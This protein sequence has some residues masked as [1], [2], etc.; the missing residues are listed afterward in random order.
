MDDLSHISS[1]KII[2]QLWSHLAT[3]RK[4]QI[5][6]LFF[7]I[8]VSGGSELITLAAAVPFLQAIRE[9]SELLSLPQI[10][11]I[12]SLFNITNP[13]VM[14]VLLTL[15]FILLAT[16]SGCIRLSN[17]WLNARLSAVI[18]SDLSCEIY[19]RTLYQPYQTHLERNSSDV[20]NTTTREL[21]TTVGVIKLTLQFFTGAFLSIVLLI[22]LLLINWFIACTAAIVFGLTYCILALTIRR[23]LGRNSRFVTSARQRQVKTLQEGLGGIRDVLLDGTQ[24]TF[25]KLY[26]DDD[27]PMR[28]RQF[29]NNFL[30]SF[31]RFTLEII[32]IILL[33]FLGMILSLDGKSDI[34]VLPVMGSFALGAQ[35]LLPSMQQTYASW[36]GIRSNSAAVLKVIGIL[37]EPIIAE[38]SW[39]NS[40]P[41]KKFIKIKISNLSFR[42]AQSTNYVLT[43]LNIE[44]NK[45]EKIGIVGSTGTGKSTL[46]DVIM[47]LIPP[48]NGKV[49]IN[50]LD[51]YDKSYPDRISEWRATIA[52]V[53][54]KIFLSDRTFYENIAFGIP[55][56]E[57]DFER[58][59]KVA[60]QARISS[61]IESLPL[62]YDTYV[63]E[64]GSRVS[65]GQAQ[66]IGI[67]RALYKQAKVLIFDEATSSLDYATENAV[68]NSINMLS[69]DLTIV[70]IAHRLST[71]DQ[72]DKIIDIEKEMMNK[73]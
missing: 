20:I 21:T 65:G 68:I 51:L 57:I 60:K 17:L 16:L 30:A 72:C 19:R 24:K 14:V 61:F 39:L 45:G 42:Y 11:P 5:T 70:M 9:P 69:K 73:I 40:K 35:K 41:L 31:P 43:N 18:G 22:G 67:A 13:S 32:G 28:R 71:L 15:L 44:I 29:Q 7:L 63:G 6:G 55:K 62:N 26:E 2:L 38:E 66:R 46:I 27:R 1:R 12:I 23:Q 36:A 25:V 49:L 10:Q 50:N 34:D 33:A 4:I 56:D 59:R 3:K 54:Q 64:R 52:H 48:T 58:V 8:L 47:G 37:D 53:P